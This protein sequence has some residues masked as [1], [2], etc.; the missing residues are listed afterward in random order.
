MRQCLPYGRLRHR[1]SPGSALRWWLPTQGTARGAHSSAFFFA[2]NRPF[3]AAWVDADSQ[4]GSD[5]FGQC[6]RLDRA[7]GPH[8]PFDKRHQVGV[9]LMRAFRA[10]LF[11][12]EARQTVTRKGCLGLI[13]RWTGHS[14][15][16]GGLRLGRAA[17]TG[18]AQHLVLHLHQ[19]VRIEEVP[20]S[21]PCRV[22][23]L[24]MRIERA[25]FGKAFMLG[26]WLGHDGDVSLLCNIKYA[27]HS[28]MSRTN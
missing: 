1:S 24:G 15:Q 23:V 5:L 7:V 3:D 26:I 16:C 2:G 18:V 25:K 12:Q 27:A 14:E 6:P 19:V 13:E 10:A 11:G 17:G 20:R 9:E 21:K 4:F 28:G 8:P 22:Y